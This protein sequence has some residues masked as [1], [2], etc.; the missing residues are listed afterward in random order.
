MFNGLDRKN[1][2]MKRLKDAEAMAY[3]SGYDKAISDCRQA[4]YCSNYEVEKE[5]FRMIKRKTNVPGD[6]ISLLIVMNIYIYAEELM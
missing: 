6:K 2:E 3:F 4:L 5:S 1:G